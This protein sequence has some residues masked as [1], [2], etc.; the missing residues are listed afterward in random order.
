M[1]IIG[2]SGYKA[3]TQE[4]MEMLGVKKLPAEGIPMTLIQG[5][6]V[7]VTPTPE[8]KYYG[9]HSAYRGRKIKSSKHRIMAICGTCDQTLS[10]G[11]LHQHKCKE[12]HANKQ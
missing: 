10:V 9:D 7:Y 12:N 1:Y 2:K 4:V 3:Y 11:R 5:I 8:P 6:W